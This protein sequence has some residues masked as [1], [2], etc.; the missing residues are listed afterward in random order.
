MRTTVE[1]NNRFGWG[2]IVLMLVLLVIAWAGLYL[3][4]SPIAGL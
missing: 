4:A 1:Q 3:A 2:V